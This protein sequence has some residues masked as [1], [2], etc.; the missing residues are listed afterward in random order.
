MNAP[1]AN[2]VSVAEHAMG[3]MLSLARPVPA[4]DASMK[5]GKWEKSRFAGAEI[6]SKTLGLMGLGRGGRLRAA[7]TH[8]R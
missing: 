6:R 3:L 2:S 1:G 4:A 7:R 8:S 5:A